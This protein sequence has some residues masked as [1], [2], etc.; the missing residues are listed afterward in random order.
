M[1]EALERREKH[2]GW[3]LAGVL[4]IHLIILVPRGPVMLAALAALLTGAILRQRQT[5]L[6]AWLVR[7]ALVLGAIGV[8]I[9][10]D[11]FRLASTLGDLGAIVGALLLLRPVTHQ[12]G[13]RV[14]LCMLVLLASAILKP[15]PSVGAT[16]IVVDVIVFLLLAEQIHRPPEATV[17]LWV[18]VTRSLRVVVPVGIVVTA[19][20]WAFP[21][22]SDYSPKVWSGFS[23]SSVLNPGS[24]AEVAQSH[25]VALV[26]RFAPDQ[27]VPKPSDLYWRGQVL[28]VSGGMTWAKYSRQIER[29]RLLRQSAPGPQTGLFHYRQ[30]LASNRSGIVAVLDH[31]LYV[32]ARRDDQDVVVMDLGGAVLQAV[33]GGQLVMDVV[34][35]SEAMPDAPMQTLADGAL[36]VPKSLR[37]DPRI[38]KIL[39]EIF[40]SSMDTQARLQAV[41]RFFRKAGFRYTQRPGRTDDLGR[42]LAEQKRGFCEHYAAAGATLLRLGGVPTRVVTGYRGG[43]WNPWT[44]T[45][46]VRDSDAHAWV[47]AWDSQRGEWLRFDPTDF[48]APQLAVGIAREM[49]SSMWPWYRSGAS[50][51]AATVTTS[52]ERVEE[53]WT[54]LTT[55]EAWEHVDV[56]IFIV[57][58]GIA[59]VWL[60]RNLRAR[61]SARAENRFER[62]LIDLEDLAMRSAR[63][64]RISETPLAW[65]KRLEAAAPE[66][67]EKEVLRQFAE[68]YEEGAYRERQ[69]DDALFVRLKALKQQLRRFWRRPS[70]VS[71]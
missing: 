10:Q 23:G 29:E 54:R 69:A 26:A 16:F 61:R 63:N 71:R 67:E 46:T 38:Q 12:R 32:N 7:V 13:M 66:S 4:A 28:E 70:S 56:M 51:L 30:E 24:I 35:T 18:A 39:D 8:F 2:L 60:V 40:H 14:L 33:G 53:A 22:L 62:L 36:A 42:F 25:R 31:A 48:V 5:H 27:D 43:T 34:S 45:I 65:L 57:L 58:V 68:A 15:Y 47:E 52:L 37:S 64:R 3:I 1:N 41:A 20:F 55:S 21:N 11:Y 44:R 50:Y 9:D 49:D 19:I 59:F 6:P 17:S